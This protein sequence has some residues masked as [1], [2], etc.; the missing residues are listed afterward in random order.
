MLSAVVTEAV[1]L[2]LVKT[3]PWVT[4]KLIGGSIGGAVSFG[5]TMLG[6]VLKIASCVLSFGI[7]LIVYFIKKNQLSRNRDI[8]DYYANLLLSKWRRGDLPWPAATQPSPAAT[9]AARNA[10]AAAGS[11]TANQLPERLRMRGMHHMANKCECCIGALNKS[12]H[13]IKSPARNLPPDGRLSVCNNFR[14]FNAAIAVDDEQHAIEA[15]TAL[16]S[17]AAVLNPQVYLFTRRNEVIGW[18]GNI[19]YGMGVVLSEMKHFEALLGRA[20]DAKFLPV[21]LRKIQQLAQLYDLFKYI[22]SLDGER[23]AD[24]IDQATENLEHLIDAI[25]KYWQIAADTELSDDGAWNEAVTAFQAVRVS[26]NYDKT[27]EKI[28]T[29]PNGDGMLFHRLLGI[30]VSAT[31]ELDTKIEKL[32]KIHQD[33]PGSDC[34]L[35]YWPDQKKF[36]RDLKNSGVAEADSVLA[37]IEIVELFRKLRSQNFNH[38][39]WVKFSSDIVTRGRMQFA[40]QSIIKDQDVNSNLAL[41]KSYITSLIKAS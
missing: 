36:A 37:L 41:V 2:V 8:I 38:I 7:L 34:D 23:D 12:F 3:L 22:G 39:D 17:I 32:A 10:E 18:F 16:E 9:A 19:G 31:S 30:E 11:A 29:L 26:G 24:M 28:A 5:E 40:V 20:I 13:D 25:E 6:K 1:Y 35:S 27:Q 21:I 15:A 33:L 14:K 4:A